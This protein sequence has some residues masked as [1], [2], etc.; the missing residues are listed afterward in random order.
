M[1]SVFDQLD[2]HE[3]DRALLDP[4]LREARQDRDEIKRLRAAMETARTLIGALNDSVPSTVRAS[5]INQA[6]HILNDN[7]RH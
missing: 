3:D 6:W 4:I 2:Q 5:N 1:D 7:L